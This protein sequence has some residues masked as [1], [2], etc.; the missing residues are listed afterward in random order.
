MVWKF[1]FAA[2]WFVCCCALSAQI[3]AGVNA[4]LQ[5]MAAHAGVIF[6]G[7]V[8]EVSHNDAAGFVDVRFH[9]DQALRGCPKSGTY[10][11]REWA[12]LWTGHPERYSVGQRRLML[13][14]ARGAGGMSSP[15]GGM[16]GAIP[17]VA[18]GAEP[19]ADGTGIA[20][21]DA[22]AGVSE[23]AVDLRWI[24][25]RI[26]A[27]HP[28]S[29]TQGDWS[30]AVAPLNPSAAPAKAPGLSAVFALLQGKSGA[31]DARY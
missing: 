23:F 18:T 13:L 27:G 8:T 2:G 21:A 4:E 20:P 31:T 10:V 24:Q 3:P 30:G 22:A 14:T 17:L 5:Q 11:L 28:V 9:I 26:V 6:A 25:A 16:D 19:L 29:P 12:G 15:V 1:G 7:Q